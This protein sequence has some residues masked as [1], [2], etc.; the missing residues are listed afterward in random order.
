MV[1]ALSA[2]TLVETVC[3]AAGVVVG[4]ATEW[5]DAPGHFGAEVPR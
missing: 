4:D 3:P 1:P 5:N 2:V